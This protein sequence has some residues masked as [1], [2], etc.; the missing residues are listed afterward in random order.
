[1]NEYIRNIRKRANRDY[2]IYVRAPNYAADHNKSGI[3]YVQAA[4]CDR[5]L[6]EFIFL[7]VDGNM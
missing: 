5:N 3:F 7:A 1:M 2:R 6:S 4:K